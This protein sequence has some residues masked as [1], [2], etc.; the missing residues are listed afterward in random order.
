MAI[1][2]FHPD[3]SAI[4]PGLSGAAKWVTSPNI[5]DAWHN[6]ALSGARQCAATLNPRPP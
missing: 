5:Y 3:F 6:A 2:Y 4:S 1:A